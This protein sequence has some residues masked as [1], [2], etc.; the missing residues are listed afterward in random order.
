MRLFFAYPYST[1]ADK[2]LSEIKLNATDEFV[3][4]P[5]IAVKFGEVAPNALPILDEAKAETK[6]APIKDLLE[7]GF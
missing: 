6:A 2:S 3:G 4:R 7:I 5:R 1:K